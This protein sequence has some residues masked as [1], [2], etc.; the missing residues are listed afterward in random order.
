MKSEVYKKYIKR[1]LDM[2]IAYVLI[3]LLLPLFILL[4]VLVRC[5][6]GS[7][8]IYKQQRPGLHEKLFIIYKFRTMSDK[9]NDRGELLADSER[10]TRFG[11][12]LRATS[13]DELP[14]LFN[15][16]LG[17]M[18]FVGP[19][20]LLKEYLPHYNENQHR[21]H[22][23]RPGLTGL[24]QIHGRNA[25]GWNDRFSLDL[26]Y[27][28]NISLTGDIKIILTTLKK[29]WIREGIHSKTAVTMEPFAKSHLLIIG[30]G[31]HGKVV[32]GIAQQMNCWTDIVFLDDNKLLDTVMDLPVI[33]TTEEVKRYIHQYDIFIAIGDN[34]KRELKFLELEAAGASIPTLIHPS[35][36]I[37]N[38]VTIEK[39]SVIMAGTVINCC[40]H[41]GKG[42]IVNTGA[43]IDHDNVIEDFV[44]LSPGVHTSGTVA[45]G[46]CTWLGVGSVVGNNLSIHG[47]CVIGAGAVVVKDLL[48]AG[49]Y[50]GVPAKMK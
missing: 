3:I 41:I 28:E 50:V 11:S 1:P 24:A 12:F 2:C 46:K 10:L 35:A 21:R 9:K 39:G 18:S 7:P 17:H 31:G 34:H 22:E 29:V 37:G 23:V 33:A 13:L 40:S 26:R 16:V 48:E 4:S 38:Q 20:P 32:A 14:E 30:A 15:I 5:N 6:M 42:C 43:T 45:V 27:I 25:I 8:I 36:I 44:H 49:T 47:D 19:R